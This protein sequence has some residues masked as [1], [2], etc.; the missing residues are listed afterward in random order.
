MTFTPDD[1]VDFTSATST[2]IVNV[3]LPVLTITANNNSKIYGDTASDTGTISGLQGNDDITV[4]FSSAGDAAGAAVGTGT[5]TITATLSD[6]DGKLGN[7]VIQ[8]TDATLTVGKANATVVV[9][10]YTVTYDGTPQTAS[11]TITGVNDETGATVGSVA[12]NSTHTDAG[13]YASDSWSFTG[14]ANYNGIA[15]TA[16]TDVIGKANATVH[17]HALHRHL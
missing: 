12:L 17:G 8:E 16:I 2:V 10:P 6:P 11:Y 1:S 15:S 13:A 14:T 5:Y 4:T 7:Y 3:S 9:T